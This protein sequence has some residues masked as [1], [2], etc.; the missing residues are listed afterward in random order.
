MNTYT[1]Q[2]KALEA[3]AQLCIMQTTTT[4]VLAT[5]ESPPDIEKLCDTLVIFIKTL[6][7]KKNE[8]K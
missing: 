7:E 2:E 6:A 3:I 5:K 8:Q 4:L 1:F